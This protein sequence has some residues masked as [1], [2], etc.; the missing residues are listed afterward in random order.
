VQQL[1]EYKKYKERSFLLQRRLE[2]FRRR[3]DRPHMAPGADDLE[4]L[5]PIPIGNVTVWDLFTAFHRIQLALGA[6]GPVRFVVRDRPL[7]EYI[8]TV[9]AALERAPDRTAR[10][11][12]LFLETPTRAEAIG[13]LLAILE[14]AKQCRLA[15]RQEELFGPISVRLHD[16][17]ERQRLLAFA[18]DEAAP[19]DDPAQALLL[20]G[21][22]REALLEPIPEAGEAPAEEDADD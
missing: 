21:E 19:P 11:E 14:M 13:L 15:L 18:A 10:F 17:E 5:G 20:E 1:L 22:G 4:A 6:R 16:E 3:Y 2:E 12:D 7:E 9:Q 8:A